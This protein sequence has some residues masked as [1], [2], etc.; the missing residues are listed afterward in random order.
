MDPKECGKCNN[1]F[2]KILNV[3]MLLL[4]LTAIV[5]TSLLAGYYILTGREQEKQEELA[6][7]FHEQ[8]PPFLDSEGNA[9]ADQDV[10][11]QFFG[12]LRECYP[13]LTAWLTIPGTVIDYPVMYREGDSEYYLYRDYE[14]NPVR[15]GSLFLD[16]GCRL[17]PGGNGEAESGNLL[18]Y[19][20]NM[21]NGSMFAVLTEYQAP[22]FAQEHSL[23][24]LY[25]EEKTQVYEVMAVILTDVG[26]EDGGQF[27]NLLNEAGESN[28][29]E[30][31]EAYVKLVKSRSLIDTEVTA[32]YGDSLLTLSTCAYQ[33]ENGRCLVI[34]RAVPVTT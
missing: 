11:N 24:I 27:Y 31:F 33:S 12:D 28:R 13:E 30:A 2:N 15:S 25:T 18:I 26:A 29:R 1:G 9:C 23:V 16:G 8:M 3:I 22:D 6:A 10:A 21:K 20:H 4:F 32:E 34:C 19:G 17:H 14:G 5:L 7:L